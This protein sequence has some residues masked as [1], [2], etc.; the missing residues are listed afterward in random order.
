MTRMKLLCIF[1][2]LINMLFVEQTFR[3][4]KSTSLPKI[5][6]TILLCGGGF[7]SR[8]RQGKRSSFNDVHF[9][10]STQNNFV[11]ILFFNN[12]NF[13][14]VIHLV[15]WTVCAFHFLNLESLKT[16]YASLFTFRDFRH[17]CTIILKTLKK[18]K[19]RLKACL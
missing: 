18:K 4:C 11:Q 5:L 17:R 16:I 12:P 19:K 1:I 8:A 7:P 15:C 10:T 9:A 2:D 14:F 6:V 13:F 3:Q